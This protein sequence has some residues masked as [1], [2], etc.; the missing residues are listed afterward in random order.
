MRRVNCAI[1]V[2]QGFPYIKQVWTIWR[3]DQFNRDAAHLQLLEDRL[4]LWEHNIA[5]HPTIGEFV[6]TSGEVGIYRYISGEYA[7]G[8]MVFWSKAKIAL[9]TV[10]R[11][12]TRRPAWTTRLGRALPWIR[13][14]MDL[15]SKVNPDD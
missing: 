4:S 10:T 1:D 14:A 2:H 3:E 6:E 12:S 11:I 15:W 7:V 5:S 13:T 8:Y 9:L